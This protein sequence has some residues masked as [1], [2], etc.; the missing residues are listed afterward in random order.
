MKHDI[1]PVARPDFYQ[2][3]A[4]ANH[5][6]HTDF[7]ALQP[8]LYR[9]Y[10]A[11]ATYAH[12]TDGVLTGLLST[13]AYS[14]GGLQC[15]SVGTVCTDNAFR[16]QGIMSHLFAY[17]EERVFPAYDL[18]T[19]SGRRE[20]Y[21]TFGFAKAYPCIDYQFYP[22]H[23]GG[24]MQVRP[25]VEE[26]RLFEC[27]QR[28]GN[29]VDR[30]EELFY[31]I[32]FSGRQ[33]PY[34]LVGPDMR[35]YAV[36]RESERRITELCGNVPAKLAA[37]VMVNRWGA[38]KIYLRG[39]NNVLDPLL[40]DT[41]D[42]YSVRIHGNLRIQRPEQV[43]RALAEPQNTGQAVIRLGEHTYRLEAAP[44]RVTLLEEEGPPE[45]EYDRLS[46]AYALLGHGLGTDPVRRLLRIKLPSSIFSLDGI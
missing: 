38:G 22:G 33:R 18:I 29:G 39:S 5:Q 37:Q 19:L 44:G 7:D 12:T 43:I 36:C 45:A 1:R 32:L 21:E 15:L 4:F 2:A 40:L 10:D 25:A 6:F 30:S 35:A 9:H 26:D 42:S 34:L 20:R 8:K 27:F 31:D 14:W 23:V 41:C 24:G 11:G 46:L 13:Y 3:I 28:Y 16:G 17:L